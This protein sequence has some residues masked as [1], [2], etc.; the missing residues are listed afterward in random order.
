MRVG[1]A[2]CSSH[3]LTQPTVRPIANIAV[4]IEVGMPSAL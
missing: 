2:D 3:W 1:L 4:N